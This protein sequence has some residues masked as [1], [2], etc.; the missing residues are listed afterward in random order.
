MA[1]SAS[2]RAALTPVT[3]PA[4]SPSFSSASASTSAQARLASTTM[5]LLFPASDRSAMAQRT[6]DADMPARGAAAEWHAENS[7]PAEV[8]LNQAEWQLKAPP[9]SNAKWGAVRCQARASAT[10][11]ALS[12]SVSA[13]VREAGAPEAT[14]PGSR[15]GPRTILRSTKK[16]ATKRAMHLEFGKTFTPSFDLGTST[17]SR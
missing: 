1:A 10:L 6:R 5:R 9:D 14:Q 17:V 4:G 2:A 8:A 7:A 3:V 12:S 13:H 11:C 15:P 16:R